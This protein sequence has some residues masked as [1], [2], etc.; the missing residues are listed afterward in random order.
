MS[1]CN[2]RL[3]GIK[4]NKFVYVSERA[5]AEQGLRNIMRALCMVHYFPVTTDLSG[6]TIMV[7]ADTQQ[8]AIDRYFALQDTKIDLA[9]YY[10]R[11]YGKEADHE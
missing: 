6:R 7:E 11:T 4:D 5:I 9:N 3:V 1:T 10:Q 2:Q 8:Q